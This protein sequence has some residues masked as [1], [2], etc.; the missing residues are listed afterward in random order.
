MLN[1][2]ILSGGL[3]GAGGDAGTP[4]TVPS[5]NGG[6]GG[7]GGFVQGGGVYV[8]NGNNGAATFI[9]TTIASNQAT[10]SA[11]GGAPGSGAGAGG[12]T[13]DY[14][15]NGQALGG[16]YYANGGTNTLGNTIIALNSGTIGPDVYGTFNSQG[17]NIIGSPLGTV[18]N[19]F[20]ASD[21]TNV[22][23]AQLNLGPLQDNGGPTLTDSLLA[24][25][26]ALA[27]GSILLV[28][29]GV[30]TDQ[31]GPGFNRIVNNSVD[32]GTV[33]VQNPPIAVTPTTLPAGLV[34][35]S[36]NQTLTASGGTGNLSLNYQ[37]T[38]GT[39]PA[40]LSFSVNNNHLNITGTPTATG[41]VSFTLN[42]SD[43]SG[44]TDSQDYTLSVNPAITF[45]PTSL[46]SGTVNTAYSQTI[47]ATGSSGALS[48]NYNVTS[49]TI[50]AGMN[51]SINANQLIITGTPTT[52]GTLTFT[53]TATD[54]NNNQATRNYTLT[55]NAAG[56]NITFSP[57]SVPDGTVNSAYNQAITAS[58]GTG[59]LTV[60][61]NITS[62]GIP[63]GLNFNASGNTL[64]I[65]GTPTAGGNVSFAVVATDSNNNQ[66]TQNYSLTVNA[67][68][69]GITFT[70]NT[71]PVANVGT[72]Y[73]QSISASS[74]NG[75][76]TLTTNL[77]PGSLP[78]GLSYTI[79]GDTMTISGTPT[80]IGSVS[81][82][83]T[84][85]D[86]SNNQLTKNYTLNVNAAGVTIAFTPNSLPSANVN[87]PY[88]QSITASSSGGSVTL[89]TNLAQNALPAGLSYSINGDTMTISGTP[90]SGGSISFNVTATDSSNNQLT[91]S[92]TLTA[93]ASGATITLSPSSLSSG[94]VGTGYG[95]TI[96]ASGGSGSITVTY[97]VSSGGIPA[98][99]SFNASGNHLTISGTPTAA[100][101]VN[102]AVTAHDTSGDV[103][104]QNYTLT[105][106]GSASPPPSPP[107][108]PTFATTTTLV[109]V[110]STFVGFTQVETIVAQVTNAFGIPISQGIVTF[111]V[112]GQTVFA[113]VVNGMAVVNVASGVLDP[114]LLY[115]LFFMHALTVDFS[116]AGGSF[117]AS[118]TSTSVPP[119]LLEFYL[120]LISEQLAPLGQ[121]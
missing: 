83:V 32:V 108:T 28:P 74:G 118:G 113:P 9:N 29:N 91:K 51:F 97:S 77:S 60:A 70:P 73:V 89:T 24:N 56:V 98:G 85:T 94:S 100:G 50:P 46:P 4:A 103:T 3:G 15:A 25:S 20:V 84:A 99:L 26:S 42:I 12:E 10:S 95:Q 66:A 14:G 31:R 111:Q 120:W 96:T 33:E 37:I 58:G 115:N 106:S 64:T 11:L 62:G 52:N 23:P 68:T 80:A 38:S 47:T 117:T 90:T 35:S 119:I 71:L 27:A 54:S 87:T 18:A 105:V 93:N 109:G 81:F 102:F 86:S 75:S 36:Y 41:T 57:T 2:N 88:N 55:V 116:D 21:H 114:S 45:S 6:N 63:S 7:D 78:A 112:N 65:S 92:Y 16:G 8:N 101:S 39:I 104:T 34:G 59:T 82:N 43:T 110:T 5:N 44:D 48:V 19:G 107:A 67:V 13:G 49:G 69:S 121:G 1:S 61:Y 17:N 53:L 72:T 30:T 40:G 76:V 79:N 22:S